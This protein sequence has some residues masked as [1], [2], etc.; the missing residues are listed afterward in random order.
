MKRNKQDTVRRSVKRGDSRNSSTTSIRALRPSRSA[1]TLDVSSLI[2]AARIA[3]RHRASCDAIFDLIDDDD[4]ESVA[5]EVVEV[6]FDDDEE[7]GSSSSGDLEMIAGLLVDES[8]D[9]EEEE[10]ASLL[11]SVALPF[12]S[13]VKQ[14]PS[15]IKKKHAKKDLAFQSK[16]GS[17]KKEKDKVSSSPYA[18][19]GSSR[20]L[21]PPESE[22]SE[23]RKTMTV[24]LDLD[25]TIVW[26]RSS[27]IVVRPFLTEL[28]CSCQ[29]HGCEVILWTAGVPA[30]VNRIIH[31][32]NRTLQ[33]A[34]HPFH[35]Y[36]Y[37]IPRSPLWF[38]EDRVSVKDVRLLQ[39]NL[40]RV[41]VI[42][43]SPASVQLQ[44]DNVLLVEDFYG[45]SGDDQSL[46]FVGQVVARAA[47]AV[48]NGRSVADALKEDSVTVPVTFE[49]AA[50]HS[51]SGQPTMVTSTGLRY[52]AL[53]DEAKE[54]RVYSGISPT[55]VGE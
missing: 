33:D 55:A 21:V 16:C 1:P 4:A 50:E 31:A 5:T 29:R 52:V 47:V 23:A 37:V 28:L 34:H 53:S 48:A 39:R 46:V 42:E 25:E 3:T 49:L 32:V 30:Y 12:A 35:W 15:H 19:P 41:L 43:N 26:A 40:D 54:N 7:R 44:P 51:A 27:C 24:V 13:N 10:E 38:V 18:L 14:T 6:T 8:S 2:R 22:S 11:L 36:S 20:M 45:Q 9:E 17:T